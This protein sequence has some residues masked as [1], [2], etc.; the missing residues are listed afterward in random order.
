M[1]DILAEAER[2]TRN[3]YREMVL[4]GV[5][6]GGYGKDMGGRANL[7]A[8]LRELLGIKGIGRLRLGS[9]EMSDVSPELLSLIASDRRICPHFHIPLQSGGDEILRKMNRKYV[10]REYLKL[11]ESIKSTIVLPALTTDVIVGFPGES[12][13]AFSRTVDFCRTVGFS[14]IHV[15]SFSP[16]PGTPAAEMPGRVPPNVIRRRKGQLQAVAAELAD[17]Y[18]AQ[19][20]GREAEL[21]VEYGR[22]RRTGLLH[23]HTERY[24]GVLIDGP[25]DWVGTIQRVRITES[26]EGHLRGEREMH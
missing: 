10:A 9:I 14:R 3:G 21:L 11:M 26:L 6:I 16:R 19:M 12:E 15:F 24:V 1:A 17:A 20:I 23:G 18:R 25:G 2:L 8:L 7:T 22:D 4:T 5:H 13:A